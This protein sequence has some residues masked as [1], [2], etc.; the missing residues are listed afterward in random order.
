M[1]LWMIEEFAF[2]LCHLHKDDQDGALVLGH[3]LLL[4]AH[5]WCCQKRGSCCAGPTPL[6]R[7][8]VCT[9]K[10]LEH[11]V[12][13]T[14]TIQLEHLHGWCLTIL[15]GRQSTTTLQV[16]NI[17]PNCRTSNRQSVQ[18]IAYALPSAYIHL[19]WH[20][21]SKAR[22]RK[23]RLLRDVPNPGVIP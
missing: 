3:E 23:P 12:L 19:L 7:L 17:Q 1:F 13:V 11:A 21:S 4:L 22:A 20:R 6:D 10:T 2:V 18:R 16:R 9:S 5:S 15:W 8:P 14:N